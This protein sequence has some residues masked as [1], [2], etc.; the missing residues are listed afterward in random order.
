[1][2]ADSLCPLY[3]HSRLGQGTALRQLMAEFGRYYEVRRRW[4]LN[5]LSPTQLGLS[6]CVKG[7][8]TPAAYG[9]CCILGR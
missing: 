3:P 5:G 7:C 8:R 2:R 6:S 1:M 9:C 4:K